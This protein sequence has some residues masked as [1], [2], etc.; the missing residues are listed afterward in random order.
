MKHLSRAARPSLA[1]LATPAF[2]AAAVG[3]VAMALVA[4]PSPSRAASFTVNNRAD[5]PD[6]TPG[7]GVCATDTGACTLRAAIEET[8]SLLGADAVIVPAGRYKLTAGGLTIT[9][10]LTITGEGAT[11]TAVDGNRKARV[12]S[13]TSPASV[14]LSQL[15]IQKGLADSSFGNGGG[16]GLYIEVG[17][18]VAVTDITFSTNEAKNVGG[19]CENDG[20]A[21]FSNVIFARNRAVFSGGGLR[22][23]GTAI[24]TNVTFTENQASVDGGGGLDNFFGGTVTLTNSTFKGNR[25]TRNRTFLGDTLGGGFRNGGVATLTN[26]AFTGNRIVGD[27]YSGGGGMENTGTAT[28][29]NVTLAKNKVV[30]S[31]K[32]GGIYNLF[33][34][35]TLTNVTFAGNQVSGRGSGGGA[36]CVDAGGNVTL[37]NVTFADN[38]AKGAVTYG[39]SLANFD[40]GLVTLRNTIVAG[41]NS[42]AGTI[43]SFGNN[44]DSGNTCGFI[45][46]DDLIRTDPLL[47]PLGSNGGFTQTVAPLP[48]SPA[49]D[50]GSNAACGL[51]DQRG[52][53]RPVDG[54]HDGNAN[55]DIGAY[56]V[57][58]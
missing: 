14:A 52:A 35:I 2:T 55:C 47:A 8:N 22:N 41:A 20:S 36:L 16:G 25:A 23:L 32:G 10:D 19:G 24:L 54:D 33:G 43:T 42:C 31:G 34:D 56:E 45:E 12:F 9:D 44:I 48:G 46:G 11:R 50:G 40:V 38:H 30:G 57:Q 5:A 3:V 28:L 17:A 27:Y 49:I 26:V 58:P 13:I 51:S 1:H 39:S 53:P 18:T 6:A 37:I 21:T 15:T 4:L 7:D 29:T